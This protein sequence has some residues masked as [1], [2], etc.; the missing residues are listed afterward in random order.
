MS[1]IVIFIFQMSVLPKTGVEFSDKFDGGISCSVA[2]EYDLTHW[3]WFLTHS[4][5][6]VGNHFCVNVVN[7]ARLDSLR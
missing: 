2:L 6:V 7:R 4:G 5:L 3:A 1:K